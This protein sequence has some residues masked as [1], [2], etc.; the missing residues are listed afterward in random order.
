MKKRSMDGELEIEGLPP[1][2]YDLHEKALKMR[3]DEF[4]TVG[5]WMERHRSTK[6]AL[7]EEVEHSVPTLPGPLDS[8]IAKTTGN[9]GYANA[10]RA[11]ARAIVKRLKALAYLVAK[12]TLTGKEAEMVIDAALWRLTLEL[13]DWEAL[14]ES[15][16]ERINSCKSLNKKY[17]TERRSI[18][19]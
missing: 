16:L 18:P 5:Q 1:M 12:K 10:R 8:C 4:G 3:F 13:E 6:R 17:E 2:L 11:D 14:A 15:L 7:Q 9:L 19:S